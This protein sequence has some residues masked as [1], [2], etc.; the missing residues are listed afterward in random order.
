MNDH[1]GKPFDLDQ[2]IEV[3]RIQTGRATGEPTP[4]ATA[5]KAAPRPPLLP[6]TAMEYAQSA[7]IELETALARMGHKVGL[8]VGMLRTFLGDL[9]S[10]TPALERHVQSQDVVA[11]QRLLHTLKGL[12]ATLGLVPLSQQAAQAEKQL[13]TAPTG[14]QVLTPALVQEVVQA[15]QAGH[16]SVNTLLTLLEEEKPA[17]APAVAAHA[18]DL[19]AVRATLLTMVVQLRASDMQA[20]ETMAQLEAQWPPAHLDQLAALQQAVASLEFDAALAACSPLSNQ[21]KN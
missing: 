8:Y 9:S 3:L 20:L 18:T 2:L 4:L 13:K 12:A 16:Q 17:A 1:I 19:A 21:L 14:A 7:H 10:M 11:A 5:S 6:A 15:L